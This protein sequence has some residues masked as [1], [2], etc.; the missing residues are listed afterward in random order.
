MPSV[1]LATGL[2]NKEEFFRLL[3]GEV[4]AAV[5]EE[6]P[7]A[8]LAVVPQHFPDEDM[9]D[10]LRVAADCVAKL[11]RD[12]DLAGHADDK[13]IA[14]G[15][16]NGDGTSAAILA[17]RLQGDLRLRSFHLRSTL[18]DIGVAC[19]PQDGVTAQRLLSTAIDAAKHRRRRLGAK[20]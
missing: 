12:G 18:W 9:T 16:Y 20:L 10:V 6:R 2:L 14:I 4:D 8:V 15:L 5:R 3:T 13:I 7:C 17:Q 1:D 11:V 19:L